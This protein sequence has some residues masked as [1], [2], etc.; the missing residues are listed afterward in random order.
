MNTLE[1]EKSILQLASA[2]R[3]QLLGWI[4]F[5]RDYSPKRAMT[6]RVS[7]EGTCTT[8]PLCHLH[9]QQTIDRYLNQAAEKMMGNWS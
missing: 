5:G 2:D 1:L 6:L 4:L 8:L 3:T 9:R 7:L